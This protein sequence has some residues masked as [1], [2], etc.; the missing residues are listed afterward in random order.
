MILRAMDAIAMA[1]FWM[2]V[3]LIFPL[4]FVDRDYALYAAIT[5]MVSGVWL[6]RS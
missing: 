3:C 4:L 6:T 1:V 2:S 5:T